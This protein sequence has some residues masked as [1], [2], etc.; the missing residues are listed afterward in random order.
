[1]KIIYTAGPYRSPFGEHYVFENIMKARDASLF[2]WRN[3]GVAICPHLNTFLF[4]GAHGLPD[5]T[6]LNGDLEIIK[7]CDGI[8]MIP[9]WE[10]SD[11]SKR[12]LAWAKEHGLKAMFSYED[13]IN[14]LTDGGV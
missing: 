11:G 2:I 8:F 3:G 12:E 10:S 1:M 7:R 14:Y 5:K 9:G 13:I 6:W 4:G